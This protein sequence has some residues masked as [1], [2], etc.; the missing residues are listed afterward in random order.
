MFHGLV[1]SLIAAANAW[2]PIIKLKQIRRQNVK[3]NDGKT[4]DENTG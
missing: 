2:Q 4:A 1:L 3:S